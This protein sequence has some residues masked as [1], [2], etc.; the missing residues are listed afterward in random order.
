MAHLLK[1]LIFE[2]VA[3]VKQLDDP[4]LETHDHVSVERHD[5]RFI[6]LE[7]DVVLAALGCQVYVRYFRRAKRL[8]LVADDIE[9]DELHLYLGVIRRFP[10]HHLATLV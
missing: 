9:P 7:L 5:A 1:P 2:M 6:L 8:Q 4:M 10:Y 3:E